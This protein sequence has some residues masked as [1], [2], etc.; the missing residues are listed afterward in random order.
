MFYHLQ[1]RNKTIDW[2]YRNTSH[3][4]KYQVFWYS[5][6]Q[7]V[8]RFFSELRCLALEKV[9]FNINEMSSGCLSIQ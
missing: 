8:L 7:I 4:N 2:I 9:S 3:K 5:F 6:V 1:L